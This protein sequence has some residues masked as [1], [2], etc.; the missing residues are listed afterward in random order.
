MDGDGR[1][2]SSGISS[3]KGGTEVGFDKRGGGGGVFSRDNEGFGPR[4]KRRVGEE[5]GLGWFWVGR[6]KEELISSFSFPFTASVASSWL[7]GSFFRLSL[8]SSVGFFLHLDPPPPPP[9]G[10]PQ[11]LFLLLLLCL[12]AVDA[13]DKQQPLRRGEGGFRRIAYGRAECV[14]VGLFLPLSSLPLPE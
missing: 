3:G 13:R 9:L 10:G 8:R 14:S 1:D 5:E 12:S 11:S 4:G 6:L 7:R 2:A